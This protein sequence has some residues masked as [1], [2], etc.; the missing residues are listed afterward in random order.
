MQI[1]LEYSRELSPQRDCS[2]QIIEELTNCEEQNQILDARKHTFSLTRMTNCIRIIFGRIAMRPY[3]CHQ[4]QI[5]HIKCQIKCQIK[6]APAIACLY[7]L[8]TYTGANNYTV[9][10]ACIVRYWR[11]GKV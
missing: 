1:F 7:R 5:S 2:V 11:A 3:T 10:Y 8:V 6:C 4:F 9:S